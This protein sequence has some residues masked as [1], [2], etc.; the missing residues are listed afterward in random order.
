MTPERKT[1]IDELITKL[2]QCQAE[3]DEMRESERD[4]VTHR[5]DSAIHNIE[6]A[7]YQLEK[8]EE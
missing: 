7:I 8:I 6:E 5:L 3:C 1:R 4:E 2:K